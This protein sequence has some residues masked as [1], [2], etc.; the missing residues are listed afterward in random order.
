MITE[1]ETQPAARPARL[2]RFSRI[3]LVLGAIVV[4]VVIALAGAAVWLTSEAALSTI[5]HQLVARSGG[6]ITVEGAKGTL[7]GNVIVDRIVYRDGESVVT[8]AGIKLDHAARALLGRRLALRE[9]AIDHVDVKLGGGTN[10]PMTM[11]DTLEFPIEVLIERA[12]IGR[13]TWQSGESSGAFD[14][15]RFAYDGGRSRHRVRDFAVQGPGGTLTGSATVDAQRPFATSADLA[16]ELTKPN[17]EGRVQAQLE[18]SLE[19]LTVRAKSTVAGVAA[20]ADVK[21]APFAPQP[22][23]EGHVE[24]KDVDLARLDARWPTTRLDVTVDA[25]PSPGGFSGHAVVANAIP[26]PI[27]K[28]RVPLAQAKSAFA[29]SGV[30]LTLRDLAASVSG[31]GN[32]A[33]SGTIDIDRGHNRWKLAVNDLDLKRIHT[34]LIETKLKGRVEADVKENAQRI[35]A[36]LAQQDVRLSVD[37]RYDGKSVIADRLFAQARDGSLEGSGRF[38]VSGNQAFAVDLK[39]RRFDPAKFGDFPKGSIDATIVA[40]GALSPSIMA[41][42]DIAIA[43]GSRFAGLATQGFVRGRFTQT[44]AQRVAA[45]LLLGSNRA[46]ANGAIG[47]SGDQLKLAVVAKR[48]SEVSPWLPP[49]VPRPLTGSLSANATLETLPRAIGVALQAETR[50]LVAGSAWKL[51]RASM[52]GRWTYA[53]PF[54]DFRIA[55]LDGVDLTVDARNVVTPDGAVDGVHAEITGNA[56]SHTLAFVVNDAKRGLE[57]KLSA[58][59]A[60]AGAALAWRGRI[61]ALS[62]TGLPGIPQVALAAPT[63]FDVAPQRVVLQPFR[64]TGNGAVLDVESFRFEKSAIETRGRFTGLPLAPFIA[65]ADIDAIPTDLVVGGSWNLASQPTWRGTLSV[66]RERG[67]IYVGDPTLEGSSKHSLGVSVMELAAKLDGGRL[68]GEAK[69]VAKLGGS[70]TADFEINAASGTNPFAPSSSVRASIRAQLPSLAAFQPWVGTSARL[71][72]QAN[73]DVKIAGTLGKPQVTGEVVGTALGFDMPEYGINYREGRLR[74]VSGPQGLRLD[75][76]TFRAGDGRFVASGVIG[77]PGD[78]VPAVASRI[79]WRAE[80]FRA[81]NRPDLRLVVDGEGT[82][83]YEGRRLALRGKVVADEGTIEYRSTETTTL[84][85]DIVIVGREPRPRS[86]SDALP[87][88]VPIDLDLEVALGRNLRF[89]GEGLDARLAGRVQI[90]SKGGGSAMGKGVI[91]TVRGTYYAFGQRLDIERG[92]IIFDGPLD[93]PSLDI[94]ALR[95]NLAVEAGVEIIGTVRAPLVRLTSEPPVPD[96]EKLAWLLTGGPS[97][98]AS[99]RESAVIAAAASALSGRGG[100][101]LTQ[102]IAQQIGLDDISVAQRASTSSDPLSGQ[103]V[104]LGKRVTDRL[105]VAYEQ[106]ISIASNMLRLEYV[107]SRYMTIAVFAGTESGVSLNFRRSWR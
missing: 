107:L 96:N 77:L 52:T 7:V 22:L 39:A 103:V 62:A 12:T 24:A 104:T 14:K 94:V 83:A 51:G 26:G 43:S 70:A 102:R 46:T 27:D 20:T 58:S 40:D 66:S 63:V 44:T 73:A 34:A 79:A 85:S 3:G 36:D 98:S 48:L 89:S 87:G 10:E 37:A 69:V 54:T 6:R 75:E 15:L 101:P 57:G 38:A 9:L 99:A 72:G 84:A 29:L 64:V 5:V 4:A 19:R 60:G 81:T 82:L 45:D 49:D 74:V 105:Y 50:D 13:L 33:G 8:L 92:R 106:G 78:K 91:R 59:L 95:K 67:D 23:L 32:V 93:N 47:R 21:V 97:G 61:D 55:A 17:P 90:T 2:R 16:L 71:T 56:A 42:A 100:K 65:Y 86:R 25:K 53:Q 76:L 31:G 30:T 80:N 88:D 11:P 68:L 18:G 28:N 1:P 35:I 41:D